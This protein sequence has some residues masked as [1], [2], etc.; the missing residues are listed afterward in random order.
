MGAQTNP[1]LEARIQANSGDRDAY[2]VYGDWLSERGDPRG[3]LI[4]V[5]L[6]LENNPDDAQLRE[7][8]KALLDANN[9]AWL[10][11][12]PFPESRRK[13][14]ESQV[15][16]KWRWGF[17][18]SVRIGPTESHDT[19]KLDFPDTIG[20]VM[21]LPAIGMLREL[22]IGSKDH[23]DYPTSWGDCVEKLAETGVPPS[24]RRLE[25]NRGGYWDI[26]STELGNIA[27]L[28]PHLDK[29]E[30]LRIEMGSMSFGDVME[31]PALKKLDIYTGGLTSSELK[32]INAA[33]WPALETLW[34]CI[35]ETGN[36]YG[37]DVEMKDLEPILAAENLPAVKHLALANSS[38]A[39]QIAM[40][41]P[42]S[43]I[44]PRLETLDLS[45][46]ML[47]EEGAKAIL[48]HWDAFAHLKSLDLTHAYIGSATA[49]AL[50]AKGTVTIEDLED[51]DDEYR[52]CEISE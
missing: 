18:D 23:D 15:E 42:T 24:L 1:D 46:G 39:D 51:P 34:I 16:V 29:L 36:D 9:A 44:L 14:V 7:R 32:A 25:F 6:G 13:N 40:A 47:S 26:S 12:L 52:Y 30:E 37:C 50:R 20:K 28:Y 35:G 49:D 45:K 5:Q 10:G 3:E 21:A 41:L 8:E 4:A 48:E 2:A 33:R 43:R 27:K 31:L 11:D 22:V 17:I 38:L 19:A